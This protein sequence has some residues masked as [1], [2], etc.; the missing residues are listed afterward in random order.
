MCV[1]LSGLLCQ[2]ED[3]TDCKHYKCTYESHTVLRSER[4]LCR[5]NVRSLSFCV[6]YIKLCLSLITISTELALDSWCVTGAHTH[7][8]AS[9]RVCQ[10]RWAE[11]V[12]DRL[13]VV[14][15]AQALW[16]QM[17]YMSE[18]L[19]LSVNTLVL[20]KHV[21]VCFLAEG[22]GWRQSREE[23]QSCTLPT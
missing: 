8:Q 21:F 7:V 5:M 15:R 17:Y 2:I 11:E 20:I 1:A 22:G 6:S 14:I 18:R 16:Y 10:T 3:V 23:V 13:N 19:Q 9:Q 4:L 12:T